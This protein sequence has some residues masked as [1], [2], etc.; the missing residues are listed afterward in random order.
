MTRQVDDMVACSVFINASALSQLDDHFM[1]AGEVSM[2]PGDYRGYRYALW[3]DFICK[4]LTMGAKS[5]L[6]R[7]ISERR[8]VS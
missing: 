6:R 5:T 2:N 7:S 3:A 1:R 4:A 8:I